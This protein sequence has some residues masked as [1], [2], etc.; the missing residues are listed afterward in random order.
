MLNLACGEGVY[1]P[2]FKRAG[3]V[4]LTGVDTSQEMIALAQ[5]EER[6]EP[7]SCRY[8]REDAATFTPDAPIDIVTAVYLLNRAGTSEALDR[9]CQA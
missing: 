7:R 6:V 8:V 2:E 3:A 1:T 4:D 9:F 5:A